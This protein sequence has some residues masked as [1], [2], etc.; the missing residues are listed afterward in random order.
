MQVAVV[1]PL[2]VRT[3][4]NAPLAV[5]GATE[6]LLLAALAARAPQVVSTD[7]LI[8]VLWADRPPAAPL[9]ALRSC[10][11]TLRADLEPGLP[12][13]VSGRYVLRRGAGYVL[14]VQR[15]DVDA[16]RIG[17]L[18]ERG[19]D[20]L[21]AG[22]PDDAVRLLT[23]ALA[24]WRGEP[25]ADWRDAAFAQAERD[26]LIQLRSGV[27]AD[28]DQARRRMH[29]VTAAATT[30][31]EVPTPTGPEWLEPPVAAPPDGSADPAGRGTPA[32][33][34]GHDQIAG[35]SR[36]RPRRGVVVAAALV[37][38]LVVAVLAGRS[39]R[40]AEDATEQAAVAEANR[41]AASGADS[42]PLD[43]ALLLTAQ[44]FRL[45]DTTQTRTAM[46]DA[47]AAHPRVERVT[48]LAGYPA[49]AAILSG[50]AGT[51]AFGAGSEVVSWSVGPESSPRASG[52]G[53]SDW[54]DEWL[55]AAPGARGGD[56]LAAG[57][58]D[59]VPWVRLVAADGG[60]SRLLAE[61]DRV[62]GRPLA[63]AVTAGG[64]MLLLV[65]RPDEARPTEDTDWALV[66]VG[67]DGSI[68]VGTG[69]TFP[70]PEVTLG[71]HFADDGRS[72][73]LWDVADL[74]PA[75]IVDVP[76]GGRVLVQPGR[77]YGISR[78]FR[79][80]PSGAAQLWNDG[81]VTLFD[82]RGLAIQVLERHAGVVRDVAVSLDGGWAVTAGA[83]GEVFRW[84]VDP[85]TGLWSEPEFL[86]AHA[87]D[88]LDVEVADAGRTL[89]TVGAD[90][91]AVR[92][93]MRPGAGPADSAVPGGP[94]QWLRELCAVVGRDL[95]PAEWERHLPDRPYAAT[96]TDLR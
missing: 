14:A 9:E 91:T 54:A 19:R 10:V 40:A 37:A 35:S 13:N 81:T 30:T 26:R 95:T 92:W 5:P 49:E 11:R 90:G 28:L 20:R 86:P 82:R 39:D 70:G 88:V 66:E 6:R 55:V 89:V 29:A 34:A 87:G 56:I 63:G 50:R 41:L 45:A 72:V 52:G 57:T 75:T 44:A 60:S 96:C 76:G 4:G 21:A 15:G 1:G 42:G 8:A 62:G 18:S 65:T 31:A 12:G 24:L 43:L 84:H 69:G 61:G 36:Q 25:Y 71:A 38:A 33:E 17:L 32:T 27:E 3:D 2:Q 78:G 16:Q 79:A 67:A 77:R 22:Q 93:D 53:P 83:R 46:S 85:V 64:R 74:T 58:A 59:G 80:L 23:E 94:E 51:I 7:A 48:R 47:L 73:V 68:D